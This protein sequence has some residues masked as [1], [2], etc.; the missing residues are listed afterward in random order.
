MNDHTRLVQ[1][2][3]DGERRI[4]CGAPFHFSLIHDVTTVKVTLQLLDIVWLR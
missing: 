1:P 3:L 2:A 4:V